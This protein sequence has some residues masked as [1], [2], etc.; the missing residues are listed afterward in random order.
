MIVVFASGSGT[1][2]EAIANAFPDQVKALVCNVENAK[3][4]LKAA[5]LSIPY[6]V[7]PHK[8][9]MNRACHEIALIQSIKHLKGIKVIVLAGY[10][11]IL[12]A[13]FFKEIL[14]IQPTPLLINLHPAPLYL[15]KGAHAYEFAADN[16]YTK[17]GLSVHEV[18][19]ELD[20][21]KL[22]N[23]LEFPVFPYETSDQI[24]ER[25]RSLEHKLLIQTLHKI[26]FQENISL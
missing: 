12:S 16:K 2:F 26:L 4:I 23:S 7:I 21:G 15:Y 9:Y 13:T 19:P 14:K 18:I 22:L 17:W 6:Y 24:R 8:D 1:N 10:M 3:V 5:H 11:R 20:S 25:A